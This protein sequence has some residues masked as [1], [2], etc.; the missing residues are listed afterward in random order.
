[1]SAA[2]RARIRRG[3]LRL[4]LLAAAL[5]AWPGNARADGLV[6]SLSKTRV[7]ITSSFTGENIVLFGVIEPGADMPATGASPAHD[8]VVTVRGPN[9]SFIARRK[10]RRL[11]LW[12]NVDSRSFLAAPSYL[13]VLSNRDPMLMSDADTLRQEQAGFGNNRLLQRIGADYADVV[14]QDPF[15][16]A[17]LRVKQAQGLYVE[18]VSGVE[19]IAP[20]VFRAVFPIPGRAP[21]GTYE[22]VVKVFTDHIL[23]QRAALRLDVAKVDFEQAVAGAAQDHPWLYGF[24]CAFGAIAVGFCANIVFRRD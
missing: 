24:I 9:Q 23:T 5:L 10:E 11:G 22:V 18:N 2:R 7:T 3:A 8:V 15:R 21:I 17:F 20:R 14:P 6:L 19:F 16:Q 1:M 12:I 13:A 4:L